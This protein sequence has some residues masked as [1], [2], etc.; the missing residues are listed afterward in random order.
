ML[1][2]PLVRRGRFAWWWGTGRRGG[3]GGATAGGRGRARALV[4]EPDQLR[5]HGAR[6]GPESRPA[7][8][9]MA[10]AVST[11]RRPQY[12]AEK[13]TTP[14]LEAKKTWLENDRAFASDRFRETSQALQRPR[15]FRCALA[16][17]GSSMLCPC[18]RAPRRPRVSRSP[19]GGRGYG[20][21]TRMPS[22][23]GPGR[24]STPG[25]ARWP[26]D[27]RQ[28]RAQPASGR[29]ACAASLPSRAARKEGG[30]A[31]GSLLFC[32]QRLDRARCCNALESL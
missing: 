10:A 12:S 7:D 15:P 28:G 8:V 6:P 9:A 22:W 24:C 30:A 11:A 31:G 21:R 17:A 19:R 2:W 5:R 18:C 3:G 27:G 32:P 13:R 20:G 23:S 25:S 14:K 1:T 26:R 16:I 4:R 29:A